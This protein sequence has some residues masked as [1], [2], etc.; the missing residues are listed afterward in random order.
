MKII[1]QILR[2]VKLS[3]MERSRKASFVEIAKYVLYTLTDLSFIIGILWA[4]KTF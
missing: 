3:N 1:V 4:L 2:L